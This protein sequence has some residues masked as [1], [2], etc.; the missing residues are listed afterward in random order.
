MRVPW[1]HF[2]HAGHSKSRAIPPKISCPKVE[3]LSSLFRAASPGPG[4]VLAMA[5]ALSKHIWK[6]GGRE[7][8]CG[9]SYP[10]ASIHTVASANKKP[11][12][13]STW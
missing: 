10:C 1:T 8:R 3:I 9:V 12:A 2:G 7:E 11:S 5:W 13:L 6:E 4:A